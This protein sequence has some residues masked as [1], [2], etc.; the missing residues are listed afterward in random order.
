MVL[1]LLVVSLGS[2]PVIVLFVSYIS[3]IDVELYIVYNIIKKLA[4]IMKI[5]SASV[6]SDTGKDLAGRCSLTYVS[7]I[8]QIDVKRG[9][10]IMN[11]AVKNSKANNLFR[12]LVSELCQTLYYPCNAKYTAK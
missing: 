8:L 4:D 7:Q 10:P 3:D 12:I 2:I 5:S 1:L 9:S 6:H 11:Y